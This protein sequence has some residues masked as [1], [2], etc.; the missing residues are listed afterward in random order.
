[1]SLRPHCTPFRLA[2]AVGFTLSVPSNACEPAPVLQRQLDQSDVIAT[3]MFRTG[4]RHVKPTS[5][6]ELIDGVAE[7]K[8][9]VVSRNRTKTRPPFRIRFSYEVDSQMGCIF[10]RMPPG[11]GA[12]VKAYLRRSRTDP[13]EFELIH[14]ELLQD[15]AV[16]GDS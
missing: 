7:L 9:D 16:D 2:I 5:A 4:E 15:I 3:G 13:K 11:D 12:H 14:Y 1:M 6:G 10:G 8:A